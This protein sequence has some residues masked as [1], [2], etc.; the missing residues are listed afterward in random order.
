VVGRADERAGLGQL[1]GDPLEVR[2]RL[3][4]PREVVEADGLPAGLRRPGG[5]ADLEQAQVVV[6]ARAL[7]L[8]ERGAAQPGHVGQR[9]EPEDVAVELDAAA[10]VADVEHSVVKSMYG[11][12][13]LPGLSGSSRV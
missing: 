8:Q 9:P 12:H 6:V 11:H 1:R 7:G 2:E 10:H 13:G 4:L 3:D 5:G